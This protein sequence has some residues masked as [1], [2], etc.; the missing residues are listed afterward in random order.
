[1]VDNP[2]NE[3]TDLPTQGDSECLKQTSGDTL[4]KKVT[5]RIQRAILWLG[6]DLLNQKVTR[7]IERVILWLGSV[8]GLLTGTLVLWDW[9]H[10]PLPSDLDVFFT[11]TEDRFLNV[12]VERGR[13]ADFRIDLTVVNRGHLTAEDV[14]LKLIDSRVSKPTYS[15]VLTI[16]ANKEIFKQNSL[17]IG[18]SVRTMTT[19]PL[20]DIHPGE[21]TFLEGALVATVVSN[22]APFIFPGR[23]FQGGSALNDPCVMP[24]RTPE[25]FKRFIDY[26][27]LLKEHELVARISA[28][29]AS[30]RAISLYVTTGLKEYF[31]SNY[32]HLFAIESDKLVK[33]P[34]EDNRPTDKTTP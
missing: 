16:S 5:R 15:S 9:A 25:D 6:S 30:E 10:R 17:Y 23:V 21:S 2:S 24:I 11:I 31:S 4:V 8:V 26:G 1:M 3:T 34:A 20:G 18:E 29:N 19:V 14:R 28:A 13:K 27:E 12:I 32:R 33:A 22:T 7:R